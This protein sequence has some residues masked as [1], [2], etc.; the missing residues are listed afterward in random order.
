MSNRYRSSTDHPASPP[1][2]WPTGL[3]PPTAKPVWASRTAAG[4]LVVRRPSRISRDDRLVAIAAFPGSIRSG[5]RSRA[6]LRVAVF[7]Q[8]CAETTTE[9]IWSYCTAKTGARTVRYGFVPSSPVDLERTVP[10][11]SDNRSIT[12]QIRTPR[13]PSGRRNEGRCY[14]SGTWTGRSVG[15]VRPPTRSH[16]SDTSISRGT[17]SDSEVSDPRR[18]RPAKR[19]R[20]VV[21]GHTGRYRRRTSRRPGR[22]ATARR[23]TALLPDRYRYVPGRSRLCRTVWGYA[24]HGPPPQ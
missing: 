10:G 2:R 17:G 7:R 8:E 24:F 18:A 3:S 22:A 23:E 1:L 21:G 12:L 5:N 6:S 9:P 4:L 14:G 15:R 13:P 16:V 20:N 19:P 11:R